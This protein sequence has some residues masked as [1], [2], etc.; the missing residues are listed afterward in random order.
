M[1]LKTETREIAGHAYEI[2]QLAAK[3]A[4][5]VFVRLCKTLGPG[6]AALLTAA[7]KDWRV[8]AIERDEPPKSALDAEVDPDA[9]LAAAQA[10]FDR[11]EEKDWDYFRDTLLEQVKVDGKPMMTGYDLEYA[12]R[13]DEVLQVVWAAIQVNFAFASGAMSAAVRAGAAKVA[14]KA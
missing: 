9:L 6:L 13:F 1:A 12:G 10:F 2:P 11:L 8:Q 14:A 4:E 3:R 7:K 5:H